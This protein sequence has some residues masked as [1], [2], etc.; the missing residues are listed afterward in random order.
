MEQVID[1]E[2]IDLLLVEQLQ[3]SPAPLL[4]ILHAFHERDGYISESA[5]RAVSKS[6]GV[7]LADLFG[8]VTFYHHFS[9]QED[10]FNKPRVCTGPVCRLNGGHECLSALAEQGATSMPCA[11]R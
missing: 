8:T 1:Q 7:P 11:G 10:G 9:Q 2:A 4:K 3:D 6:M 5:L